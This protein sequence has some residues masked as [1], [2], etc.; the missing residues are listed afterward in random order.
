MLITSNNRYS[1]LYEIIRRRQHMS[2]AAEM[3]WSLLPP[4]TLTRAN[5]TISAIL[6]PAYE[7]GGDAF[8]YALDGN[9]VHF[10]VLDAMGHGTHASLMS[11]VTIGMHRHCRRQNL[12]LATTYRE[13]DQIIV[14]Q[15]GSGQFV[16]AQLGTL[17]CLTGVLQW[18]NA[19]HPEPMLA[20][21]TQTVL[22]LEGPSMRPLGIGRDDVAIRATQLQPHDRMMF[23][24]DGILEMR[25]QNGEEFG[26]ER[27]ADLLMTQSALGH[28]AAETMRR[29]SHSILNYH[30]GK[31]KDDASLVFFGMARQCMI[32]N[33]ITIA[34]R[35]QNLYVSV[36]FGAST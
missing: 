16:T 27:L 36:P 22:D 15:F 2:L 13:M 14:Q 32:A 25:E 3:Q 31:L 23:V 26:R 4:L 19:G 21:G 18:I 8:D 5:V 29:I 24:T 9:L 7:V 12:D 34:K 6:E 28:L 30:D 10:I 20:R 11:T 17:D 33:V 35:H 1:D